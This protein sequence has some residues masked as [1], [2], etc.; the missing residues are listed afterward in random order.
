[1]CC[2]WLLPPYKVGKLQQSACDPQSLKYLLP[3][4]LQKE[5]A[6]VYNPAH[7]HPALMARP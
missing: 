2:L 7:L 5:F 3:A 6:V 1:M 4:P